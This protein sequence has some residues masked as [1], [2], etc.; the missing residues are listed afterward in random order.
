MGITQAWA[1]WNI[2]VE[3]KGKKL[4]H[5][6]LQIITGSICEW[7]SNYIRTIVAKQNMIFFRHQNTKKAIALVEMQ[8]PNVEEERE[9]A[10]KDEYSKSKIFTHFFKGKISFISNGDHIIYSWK[11]KIFGKSCEIDLEEKG[12]KFKNT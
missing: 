9:G 2:N 11:I 7:Q 1:I 3:R 8:T 10:M 4:N 12:W 6:Q 5:T